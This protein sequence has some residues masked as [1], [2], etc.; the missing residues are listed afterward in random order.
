MKILNLTRR[1]VLAENVKIPQNYFEEAKGLIG[2]DKAEPMLFKTRWGIHTFGVRF[3]IDVII[4]D[5]NS[6]VVK[7]KNNLNPGRF[8]FWNP[9]YRN[10]LELPENEI[11]KSNLKIGDKL[12]IKE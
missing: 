3:P 5:K 12:E 7:I 6:I 2:K 8:F 9:K 1:N 4:F 11:K 10:V